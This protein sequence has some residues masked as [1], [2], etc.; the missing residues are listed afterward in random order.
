MLFKEY[1]EKDKPTLLLMH[2]MLQEAST[3]YEKLRPLEGDYRL[4]IP[5]MDG[6]YPNSPTFTCFS[7]QCRK[8]EEY[9]K[10]NYNGKIYGV[11]GISQGATI[12]SELLAR[13]NIDIEKAVL[14]GVYVAHQGKIAA[15]YGVKMYNMIK[16][17]G[18][19]FPKSMDIVMRLMGLGEED[20]EMFTV[21]NFTDVSEESLKNNFYE[22]YT[23]RANPDLKNTD[24]RVY[25]WCGS[26]EPYAKKSHNIL[27]QY[28]KN[29][30]EKIFEGLGHGQLLLRNQDKIC[31]LLR[32]IFLEPKIQESFNTNNIETDKFREIDRTKSESEIEKER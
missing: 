8:I 14:D 13:N 16:K 30:E 11:Y 20:Y 21:M 18:G 31:S 23:Y 15:W 28:I 5:T 3:M 6:M 17:N 26:K 7:E 9:I 24:T 2:G 1:G 25:L 19:K 4:I 32:E 10:Q 29:Y 27:K 12:L 22:N